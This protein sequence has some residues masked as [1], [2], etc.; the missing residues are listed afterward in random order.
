MTGVKMNK[1]I[2]GIES[3]TMNEL[4]VL[5]LVAEGLDNE[6]IAESLNVK[7]SSVPTYLRNIYQKL[8]FEGGY[9]KRAKF[10]EYTRKELGIK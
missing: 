3:L 10:V 6:D 9:G 1:P 5:K 7:T 2:T 4:K 8:G